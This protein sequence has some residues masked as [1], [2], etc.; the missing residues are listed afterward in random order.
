M[1]PLQPSFRPLANP[2]QF[3]RFLAGAGSEKGRVTLA[4]STRYDW[5]GRK[6]FFEPYLRALILHRCGV[7]KTLHDLQAGV[8]SDALYAM[9]GAHMEVSVPALSQANATRPIEPFMEVLAGV[10]QAI[11]YLP[12]SAKVLRQVDTATLRTIAHLLTDVKVFDATTFPLPPKLAKWARVNEQRA[13]FKLQLRLSGGY[14]GLDR[15]FFTRAAGNDNPSFQDLLDLQPQ[16][17]AIYLFDTGYFK[18]ETYDQI[19]ETGNHFLTLLHGKMKVEVVDEHPVP[20]AL[21]ANGYRVHADQ[22]IRLGQGKRQSSHLYRLVTVTDSRGKEARILTSLLD[23]PV[24]QVGA[25]RTY[26]WTVETVIRWL[27]KSLHLDHLISYSPKGVILQVTIALI[28]YGLL[29]VYHQRAPLSVARLLRRLRT[30]LHQALYEWGFQQGY[31]AARQEAHGLSP[32][33]PITT[34]LSETE[35][36]HL[37]SITENRK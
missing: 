17:G 36:T 18:I 7:E 34:S 27:K 8:T 4:E 20:S 30:D 6:I 13:G 12:S 31:Q 19:V 5:H 2:V 33:S 16:A 26:R 23:L 21:L 14:G 25:L 28:V 22:R 10:L 32:P 24:E 37:Q 9:V 35:L 11:E 1:L 3:H 15:I 29:V